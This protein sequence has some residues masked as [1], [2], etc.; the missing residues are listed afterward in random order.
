MI[1]EAYE[2]IGVLYV[3]DVVATKTS[4]NRNLQ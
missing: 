3:I 1:R 4:I 2:P